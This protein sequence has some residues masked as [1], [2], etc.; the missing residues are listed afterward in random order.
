[1]N[2]KVFGERNTGTNALIS[3]LRNNSDSEVFPG[4]ID[5]IAPFATKK[6]SFM[7]RVGS[8]TRQIEAEVDKAFAGKPITHQWKHAATTFS[9]DGIDNVHFIFTVRHPLSWLVSLYKNPYHLLAEK[10]DSLIDF[11]QMEWEV[12]ARDNLPKASYKPLELY[13]EKLRSYT[14]LMARLD[15]KGM[16]YT[17]VKFEDFV[18]SQ[19]QTFDAVKLYLKNPAQDF[20]EMTK[21]TKDSK[22]NADYYRHY[23]GN[24]IWREDVP[25]EVKAAATFDDAL[26][27]RYGYTL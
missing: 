11:M 3:V 15:A 7:R 2:I 9:L 17:V 4:T 27:A 12:A 25:D 14:D 21:S 19:S 6:T 18:Q 26:L 8:S 22:K 20:V 16:G 13:E 23:Y 1:M 24:E 10:P 5:E